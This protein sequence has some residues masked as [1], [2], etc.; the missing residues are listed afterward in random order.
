MQTF[1]SQAQEQQRPVPQQMYF[2][3]PAKQCERQDLVYK[4]VGQGRCGRLQ[5]QYLLQAD[6]SELQSKDPDVAQ[7]DTILDMQQFPES[8]DENGLKSGV[9]NTFTTETQL[10]E[11]QSTTDRGVNQSN[12]ALGPPAQPEKKSLTHKGKPAVGRG[13]GRGGRGRGRGKKVIGCC[14]HLFLVCM[15]VY[16]SKLTSCANCRTKLSIS[17]VSGR[18]AVECCDPQSIS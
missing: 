9:A 11:D 5:S 7:P 10:P 6:L 1:W 3:L 12:D 13:R 8:K 17:V 14:S 15:H 2:I 18:Q 4:S 16:C